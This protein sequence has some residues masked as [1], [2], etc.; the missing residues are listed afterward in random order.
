MN[1]YIFYF[2]RCIGECQARLS[3][4][5]E[6]TKKN[7]L[8]ALPY[9]KWCVPPTPLNWRKRNKDNKRIL[10]KEP[11]R[12]SE[13]ISNCAKFNDGEKQHS[14]L[15]DQRLGYFPWNKTDDLTISIKFFVNFHC[16]Q[17]PAEKLLADEVSKS[18]RA[19][20]HRGRF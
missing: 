1:N 10:K 19:V 16:C 17:N 9:D 7:C 4:K 12:M 15:S 14:Q 20:S 6:K 3:S 5:V 13:A 8:T 11:K 18:G 2:F